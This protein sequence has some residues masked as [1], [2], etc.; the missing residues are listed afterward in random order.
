VIQGEPADLVTYATAD[1]ERRLSRLE[2]EVKPDTAI[3][4][5]DL[6]DL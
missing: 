5:L 1:V 3:V 2:R 4:L 6:R